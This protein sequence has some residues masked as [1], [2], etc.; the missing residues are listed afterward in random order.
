MGNNNLYSEIFSMNNLANAWRKA[1]RDKT[2]KNYVLEFD[3]NIRENLLK[4]RDE[5][6]IS[7]EILTF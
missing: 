4:L 1:R 5:L 2:K 7:Q 6:K 3:K